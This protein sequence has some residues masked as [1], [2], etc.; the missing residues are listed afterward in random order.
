[1]H[2]VVPLL[3][4]CSLPVPCVP[5]LSVPKRS[6][7]WRHTLWPS[8]G[9]SPPHTCPSALGTHNGLCLFRKNRLLSWLLCKHYSVQQHLLLKNKIEIKTSAEALDKHDSPT[10]T[11]T[12]DT[13]MKMLVCFPWFSASLDGGMRA[14]G[15][16]G[17]CSFLVEDYWWLWMLS[18]GSDHCALGPC[19]PMHSFAKRPEPNPAHSSQVGK[20]ERGQTD[21]ETPHQLESMEY[22]PVPQKK[23]KKKD[24]LP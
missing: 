12:E 14:R 9:S 19:D 5:Q 13:G 1:M 22:S 3:F 11:T 8:Q 4:L 23:K 20:R 24:E 6:R 15:F 17:S 16:T 18:T 7:R 2:S 21:S 10:E